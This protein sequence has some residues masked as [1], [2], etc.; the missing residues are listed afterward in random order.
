MDLAR[1]PLAYFLKNIRE[2]IV[3]KVEGYLSLLVTG[4]YDSNEDLFRFN[5]H[6][7][8]G[9]ASKRAHIGFVGK[10]QR[11]FRF[12]GDRFHGDPNDA[13]QT[14]TRMVKRRH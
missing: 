7:E 13:P 14:D 6:I 8:G 9:F 1:K 12:V 10:I 3:V 2:K 5:S 11:D 4:A